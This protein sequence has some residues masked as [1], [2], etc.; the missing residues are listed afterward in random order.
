LTLGGVQPTTAAR[1]DCVEILDLPGAWPDNM[2]GI[3]FDADPPLEIEVSEAI[4]ATFANRQRA[5][6][7]VTELLDEAFINVQQEQ[8][9]QVTLVIVDADQR[10]DRARAIIARHG[11]AELDRE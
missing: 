7:A 1:V 3:A 2:L 5:L 8:D 11:G 4:L 10:P 6:A 9:G